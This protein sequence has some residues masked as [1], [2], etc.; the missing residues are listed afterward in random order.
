MRKGEGQATEASYK[1]FAEEVL[2]AEAQAIV[3]VIDHLGEDFDRAVRTLGECRGNVMVSGMGKS[4]IIGQK[5][6]ATLA[7]TGTASH[8]V[9]PTEAMHG[10]LGRI[11]AQ[12]VLVLISRSGGGE[13]VLALAALVSQDRVP[14]IAITE[15][16]QSHLSRISDL[17]LCIGDVT[18]AC[19]HNLAPTTSTTAT[20]ALAD[21]LAMAVSRYKQFT[22]AD[23]QKRHPGGSLGRLMMGV[24][25]ASRF[26][27]GRNLLALHHDKTLSEAL[28]EADA[29][30]RR[31]GALLLVDD[32]GRLS[33]IFTDAD[34]RRLLIAEGAGALEKPAREVMTAG[35]KHLGAEARVRDAVQMIRELRVDEIPIV[36][37]AGKPVALLDV[38]DLMALKVIRD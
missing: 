24:V 17:S 1:Q 31:T 9:H 12:D 33:G 27:I 32:D 21:A 8:W 6:S 7:S 11:G 3:S 37:E 13:E 25:E 19:P 18:E 29:A 10:D 26:R 22:E 4:G 23:F 15:N 35:P 30:G 28:G 5:L 20:L 2:R 14:V 34:L 16:N 36:D 38:Q